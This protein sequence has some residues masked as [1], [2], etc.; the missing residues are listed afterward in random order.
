[1]PLFTGLY[2]NLDRSADR[3]RAIEDKFARIG[4]G[5]GYARLAASEGNALG[6][7]NPHGLKTGEIGCFISH[8]RALDQNRAISAPLHVVEDDIILSPQLPQVLDWAI[9]AGHLDKYDLLFTDV[10]VPLLNDACHAYK[11]FYDAI[12]K[13]DTAGNITDT[14]FAVLDMRELIF[15]SA[16]SYLVNPASIGK[17]AGLLHK[18]LMA[19]ATMPVDLHVR[20]LCHQGVIRVGCIFPFVTTVDIDTSLSTMTE[21]RF[22]DLPA[23]A[24]NMLRRSFF[25]G[26]DWGQLCAEAGRLLPQPDAGDAHRQLMMRLLGYALTPGYKKC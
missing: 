5:G 4:L 17:L 3:R 23:M 11:A 25:I 15:A 8:Y 9:S 12:V 21:K 24:A 2:I 16:S 6:V 14:A 22:D 20:K 10:A 18:E 19:G 13:R 1:M 26:A 7:P